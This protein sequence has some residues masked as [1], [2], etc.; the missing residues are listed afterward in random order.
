MKIQDIIVIAVLSLLLV[1]GYFL[2]HHKAQKVVKPV[3]HVVVKADVTPAHAPVV[4]PVVVAPDTVTPAVPTPVVAPAPVVTPKPVVVA[5]C[6][7][8]NHGIYPRGID[9]RRC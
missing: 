1:G 9:G 8:R 4:K 3:V 7:P 2:T 6:D 5:P